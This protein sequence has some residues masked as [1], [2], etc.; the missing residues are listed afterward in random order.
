[1]AKTV[2]ASPRV[3][4]S[5]VRGCGKQTTVFRS[6][7]LLPN[8][9]HVW[10]RDA[11]RG[12]RLGN[13]TGRRFREPAQQP[14]S[15]RASLRWWPVRL[16]AR[17]AVLAAIVIA[18]AVLRFDGLLFGFPARY[19]PDEAVANVA[20]STCVAGETYESRYRHPPFLANIACGVDRV[21]KPFMPRYPGTQIHTL[22]SIRVVSAVAGT[23]TIAFVYL[24]ALH[25]VS[26]AAA[27]GAAFLF[28]GFPAAAATSK[29]GTPDS[30]L[31]MLVVA[32]L[33]LQVRLADRGDRRAYFHAALATTLAVSAKYNGAVLALSFAV[34]HV[35]AA[36]RNSRP[37]FGRE[38][39]LTSVAAIALGLAIGF[40]GVLFHGD[41]SR[42]VHGMLDER[43]HLA[44]AGHFGFEVGWREEH[45]L[46][47]F[48]HSILPATGQLL[49]AAIVAGLGVLAATRSRAAA[50]VIAFAVPYYLTVE[51][52]Y[53]VPPSYERYALPLAGLYM[54]AAA[55]LVERLVT[56]LTSAWVSGRPGLRRPPDAVRTVALTAAFLVL[57]WAPLS[58]TGALLAAIHDDTRTRMGAWV[59]DQREE[60]GLRGRVS[61]QWPMI[62]AYYPQPPIPGWLQSVE[63]GSDGL[64]KSR[65]FLASSLV[66]ER[67]LQFP[68]QRPRWTRF[69]EKLFAE[70]TLVH[71]EDAGRGRYMFHNPTLRLYRI[72][73]AR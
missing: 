4:L 41:G 45:F 64:P 35:F 2:L 49:L 56:L 46:F 30:L 40:P 42:L 37:L 60:P 73:G 43:K 18:G 10:F 59:E 69:Y 47:H 34:A 29:Y 63:S 68:E 44:E 16:N 3:C 13:S 21:V 61:A 31:T 15:G 55:M 48:R 7:A 25:F 23:V 72:G 52:V 70:G 9:A 50:V 53:K 36:R 24:L 51:L 20:V 62:H 17:S 5:Q 57:A 19:H 67:Y 39:L 27:L 11:C 66:Y 22:G 6:L 8:V 12:G 1:M 54:I 65:Y 71:E 14:W 26:P 28:A 33:W 32:A 38:A 58:R